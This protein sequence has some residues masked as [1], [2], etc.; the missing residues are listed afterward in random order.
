VS[1]ITGEI[2]SPVDLCLAN[3]RLNPAA[4][5]WSRTPQHRCNLIGQ[6]PRKKRWDYWCVVGPDF[7]FSVTIADVDYALSGFV[8]FLEFASRRFI[9]HT[10]V[11]PFPRRFAMPAAPGGS[12]KLAHRELDLE[13]VTDD[14]RGSTVLRAR[15]DRFGAHRLDATIQI[16]RQPEQES[17][18]V[19]IPW[20]DTRFQ[21]TSKQ[22]GLA[23]EGQIRLDDRVFDFNAVFRNGRVYKIH[24]DLIFDYDPANLL[25]PWRIH[26]PDVEELDLRFFPFFDRKAETNLLLIFTR[27]N[28]M[29]GRFEG[30]FRAGDRIVR[31]G[32][33]VNAIGWAEE[34]EARW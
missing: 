5:G 20:K 32:P 15:S 4:I 10:V 13:F 19:V 12:L 21:F 25:R 3:G 1:R 30:S 34:H 11:I 16:Q 24:D 9:E 7:L 29:I 22:P 33:D 14:S 28:Q 18:N 8:Y 27:V 2:Q 6:W 31:I 26:A 17:L 23:A